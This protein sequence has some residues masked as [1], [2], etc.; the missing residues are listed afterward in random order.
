MRKIKQSIRYYKMLLVEII[1]TLCT[2]CLYLESEGRHTHNQYGQYM[3]GHFNELKE[4]STEM[5][6]SLITSDERL[7]K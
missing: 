1:E 2:I 7:N 5:R 3:R 6:L 4:L